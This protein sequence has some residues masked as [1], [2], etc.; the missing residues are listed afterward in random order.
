MLLVEKAANRIVRQGNQDTQS[1]LELP[2]A[3]MHSAPLPVRVQVSPEKFMES[4][5]CTI[6]LPRLVSRCN[7]GGS[8]TFDHPHC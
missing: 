3:L 2:I 8:S 4:N 5:E 7:S 1:P 6:Y